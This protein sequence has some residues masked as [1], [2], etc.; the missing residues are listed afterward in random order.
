MLCN[1]AYCYLK[2]DEPQKAVQ[3]FHDVAEATFRSTIGLAY[4]HFK[5]KQYEESYAVYENALELLANNDTEKS[6]I[7]VALSSMVYAFQGDNEAKA[8]LFQW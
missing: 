8:V 6:L 3:A 4:S 7:L 5:A 2:S 1:K